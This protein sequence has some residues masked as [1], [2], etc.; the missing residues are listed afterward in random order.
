MSN[1]KKFLY[2]TL[3]AFL[4]ILDKNILNRIFILLLGSCPR[5]GTWGAGR[6]K[7]FSVE[8]CDG[9]PSTAHSSLLFYMLMFLGSL[10]REQY[11]P[12]SDCSLVRFHSVCLVHDKF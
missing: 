12:R 7:N 3:C 6:V 9:V 8:I 2:Q 4:Q 1:S 10:Y 11:G 5:D